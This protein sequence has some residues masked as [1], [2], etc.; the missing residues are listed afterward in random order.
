MKNQEERRAHE[1][2]IL[3]G[4]DAMR[5]CTNLDPLNF[6]HDEVIQWMN[7][8]R[9]DAEKPAVVR[10]REALEKIGKGPHDNEEFGGP[11]FAQIA[12]AALSEK[13]S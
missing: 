5:I 13:A 1:T 4:C 12:R 9:R 2:S 3:M 11:R 10:L 7:N 6:P 8:L